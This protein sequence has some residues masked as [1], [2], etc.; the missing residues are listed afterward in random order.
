MSSPYLTV[1]AVIAGVTVLQGANGLL[2]VLLP[3]R[4]TA[5]GFSVQTMGWVAAAHGAGFLIGCL[6]TSR[7]IALIGHV[8]A[9]SALAATLSV[10]ALALLPHTP[11]TRV[12]GT[13][14]RTPVGRATKPTR[15][16]DLRSRRSTIAFRGRG[17]LRGR[18]RE[19]E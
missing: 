18:G 8:R 19:H 5:K 12:I 15:I 6:A 1:T 9:F 10:V 14:T 7:L 13:A 3:L 11:T 17:R 4:M 2:L 16:W